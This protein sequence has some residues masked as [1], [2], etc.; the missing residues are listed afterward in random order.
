MANA[1]QSASYRA[2]LTSIRAILLSEVLGADGYC[3]ISKNRAP[4]GYPTER[5]IRLY[6]GKVQAITYGGGRRDTRIERNLVVELFTRMQTDPA[7]DGYAELVDVD[8]GHISLEEAIMD[9]LHGTTPMSDDPVPVPL[10]PQPI[11]MIPEG[12]EEPEEAL[13]STFITSKLL[14]KTVYIAPLEINGIPG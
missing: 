6:P 3:Y 7:G 11:W 5:W 2:I 14:F 1:V 13:D 9:S 12:A 4:L 10:L 8:Y